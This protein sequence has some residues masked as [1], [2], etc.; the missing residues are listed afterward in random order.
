MINAMMV[1]RGSRHDFDLWA[2]MGNKGWSYNDVLPYFKKIETA[3]NDEWK[4]S[5]LDL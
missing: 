5:G 2:E 1:T 4:A 3:T